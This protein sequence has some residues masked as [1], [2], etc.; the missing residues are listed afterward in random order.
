M[1]A[2][3]TFLPLSQQLNLKLE[4]FADLNEREST[5]STSKFDR[6]VESFLDRLARFDG[7][8][9]FVTHADWI[10]TATQLIPG[11]ANFSNQAPHSWPPAQSVEF[12]IQSGVW[13]F[14]KQ[15]NLKL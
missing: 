4:I 3:Q 14:R 9:Y 1:R 7:V 5:E 15:R 12:E 13:Q 8:V 11:D 6:R 10:E 2:Q